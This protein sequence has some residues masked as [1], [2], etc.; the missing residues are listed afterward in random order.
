[1][2]VGCDG[3]RTTTE[4][5]FIEGYESACTVPYGAQRV[6]GTDVCCQTFYGHI[7]TVETITVRDPVIVGR[8]VGWLA[9]PRDATVTVLCDHASFIDAAPWV[10]GE[11]EGATIPTTSGLSDEDC[12][13]GGWCADNCV[14]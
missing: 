11:C 12:L 6:T 13:V 8:A 5:D 4:S 10:D 2:I 1:M 3:W 9:V 7:I 14:Q